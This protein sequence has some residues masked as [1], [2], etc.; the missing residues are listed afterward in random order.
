MTATHARLAGQADGFCESDFCR[1]L[2]LNFAAAFLSYHQIVALRLQEQHCA[3]GL[4]SSFWPWRVSPAV[5]VETW[6]HP[7]GPLHPRWFRGVFCV[8][9]LCCYFTDQRTRL[10]R[11]QI[12]S[13]LLKKGKWRQELEHRWF[14]FVLNSCNMSAISSEIEDDTHVNAHKITWLFVGY[15]HFFPPL[16]SSR[17]WSKDA[18]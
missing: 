18:V 13:V 3:A 7:S 9:D 16:V 4:V 11:K 8:H 10:T 6:G 15:F 1:M 5:S 17:V 14:F 12:L 2:K